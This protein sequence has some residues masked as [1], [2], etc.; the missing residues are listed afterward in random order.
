M[1]KII[2]LFLVVTSFTSF[3]KSQQEVSYQD[4]QEAENIFH[5][6]QSMKMNKRQL[7]EN[8][9]KCSNNGN[10]YCSFIVGYLYFNEKD[11]INA[12]P[13]FVKAD[14][15]FKA[16]NG[17]EF[18]PSAIYLGTLYINGWAVEQDNDK[19]IIYFKECASS[20]IPMCAFTVSGL[21]ADKRNDEENHIQAYAWMLVSKK[22][23]MVKIPNTKHWSVEQWQGMLED[24]MSKE[25]IIKGNELAEKLCSSMHNCEKPK[26]WVY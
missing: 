6:A 13:F 2:F 12:F 4:I 11:Y 7:I 18:W 14:K 23:G 15:K 19:A 3:S 10:K 26:D 9:E 22:L 8:M 5:N 21:Y 24:I 20:L 16:K 17:F 1:K 25:E